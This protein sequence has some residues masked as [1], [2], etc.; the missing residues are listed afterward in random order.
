MSAWQHKR[1][2]LNHDWLKNTFI[3]QL[4]AL[5]NLTNSKSD[6]DC[7][8][9]ESCRDALEEWAEHRF[10]SRELIEAFRT[11]ESPKALFSIPPLSNCD[12]ETRSWLPDYVHQHWLNTYPVKS[13]IQD[14]LKTWEEADECA[15]KLQTA[16]NQPGRRADTLAA[17]VNDLRH[18]V[19]ALS[20]A[21]SR[22]PS[23]QLI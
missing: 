12:E 15:S 6:A 22:F 17:L 14:A 3:I 4:G 20:D 5:W 7:D 23:R 1:S 13:W 10:E 16:L 19:S 9:V 11:E 2:R 8:L 21:V 18:S